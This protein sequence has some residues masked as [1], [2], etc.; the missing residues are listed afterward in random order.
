M[1]VALLF[2]NWKG[3]LPI[4]ISSSF[5]P[6]VFHGFCLRSLP[7]GCEDFP[8]YL[9]HSWFS[10]RGFCLRLSPGHVKT[11]QIFP[12][13]FGVKGPN[14]QTFNF[15]LNSLICLRK[16]LSSVPSDSFPLM[17]DAP[18]PSQMNLCGPS[19]PKR[20]C[21]RAFKAS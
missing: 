4:A 1:A 11:F 17:R 2:H 3:E 13:L 7:E 19:I 6:P 16:H 14:F 21:W 20:G 5:F 18:H 10:N 9:E 15:H 8:D 12:S